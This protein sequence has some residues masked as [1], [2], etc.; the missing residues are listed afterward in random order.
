MFND[1]LVHIHD[2]V[3]ANATTGRVSEPNT[4]L[5][6]RRTLDSQGRIVREDGNF[7]TVTVGQTL[8]K[9]LGGSV[10]T[11]IR[12]DRQANGDYPA[13]V[14]TLV[15]VAVDTIEGRESALLALQSLISYLVCLETDQT[16]ATFGAVTFDFGGTDTPAQGDFNSVVNRILR[17][18][19]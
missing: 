3:G 10:R 6:L 18:E 15:G 4:P 11:A 5:T 17:G 19:A 2:A 14:V 13:S 7:T 9:E 8:S 1:A 16:G 12:V